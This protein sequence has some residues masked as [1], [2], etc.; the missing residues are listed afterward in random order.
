MVGNRGI[1]ASMTS[2]E[3]IGNALT[4][5]PVD[6]PPVWMMR[7]AGRTLPEYL[8]I[9]ERY[10]FWEL[11]RTPELAAKVTL[12]PLA[13]FPVDA[14]IIFSDILTVP[15]AMG[16]EVSFADGLALSPAVRDEAGLAALRTP[17]VEVDLGYVAGALRQTRR[18]LGREKALL[19]FSG[20]PYTLATYMVEGGSS[21]HYS[22]IKAL[23]FGSPSV[24]EKLADRLADVVVDYLGMQ[25]EAGADA[26]QLFDSWAGELGPEDYR[27][28]VLPGVQRIV[29]GVKPLGA[30]VIYYVNGIANVVDSVRETGVDAVSVDWRLTL[31]EARHRLGRRVALQGNLDP[32]GLF[33]PPPEIERRVFA[34]LDETDGEGHVANLGH[35]LIADTPL[36]G[37][38]AFVNATIS[39]AAQRSSDGVP[40]RGANDTKMSNVGGRPAATQQAPTAAGAEE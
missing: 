23:M 12:Q 14:A 3:R 24:Y 9:R 11:C 2:R 39:W 17:V 6:R 7:Q 36:Q 18:E 27:R 20:A 28:F 34:M 38:E 16:M 10:S 1:L 19:G 37:I 32:A 35:G 30:P 8:A 25:V 33:A 5:A 13:R 40:G 22:R 29:E 4:C 26:V 21:R 31:R 15:A